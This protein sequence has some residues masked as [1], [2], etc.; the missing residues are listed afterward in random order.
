M[1]AEELYER[2]GRDF[3]IGKYKD[4]WSFVEFNEFINPGFRE[5]YIGV[6]T[7]YQNIYYQ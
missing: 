1:K 2:I 5:R 7:Y 3:E 6:K 4:D